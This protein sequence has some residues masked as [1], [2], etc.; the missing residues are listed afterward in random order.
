MRTTALSALVILGATLGSPLR[1]VVTTHQEVS[2][3]GIYAAP[4]HADNVAHI[5]SPVPYDVRITSG[6]AY[7]GRK[8]LCQTIKNKAL[9][10]S[11]KFRDIFGFAP[12]QAEAIPA[13]TPDDNFIRILPFP[14]P[15]HAMP[16]LEHSSPH[17]EEELGD[18]GRL[19]I[20]PVGFKT[21]G[22]QEAERA[23]VLPFIGTPV[24]PAFA[25][26]EG[27]DDRW[28][29][30]GRRRFHRHHGSF[31]RRVHHALVVLGPWEGRAVAF[32]LGCG[33][34]VLLRMVW[35]MVLVTARAIRG[36]SSDRSSAG[37]PQEGIIVDGYTYDIVFDGDAEEILVPPPQYTVAAAAP[38]EVADEKAEKENL[39]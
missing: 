21:D 20:L 13:P 5:L 33:I 6:A 9:E 30:A 7:G 15:A 25:M 34:G 24:R 23:P 35:V 12:I 14:G 18:N 29:M 10:V 4:H 39:E 8:P 36:P 31:L 37:S 38:S 27:I 1:V 11:N 22:G 3:N 26:A 2:S 17:S 32:V 16:K 28:A 19:R